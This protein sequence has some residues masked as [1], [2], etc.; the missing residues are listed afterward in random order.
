MGDLKSG[1]VITGSYKLLDLQNSMSV[2][3]TSN[4]GAPT[5][6][7]LH[8]D[9][10]EAT[11]TPSHFP[12]LPYFIGSV[13]QFT[14]GF[15]GNN[16]NYAFANG[17]KYALKLRITVGTTISQKTI[18]FTYFATPTTISSFSVT[19][20]GN[21]SSND[22]LDAVVALQS[23]HGT[24]SKVQFLFDELDTV[25]PGASDKNEESLSVWQPES[26]Y[27]SDNTYKTGVNSL[28]NDRAYR[29]TA[30]A[31]WD[32]GYST[33]LNATDDLLMIAKPVI[34]AN[35]KQPNIQLDLGGGEDTALTVTLGSVLS[36]LYYKPTKVQ[37]LIYNGITLVAS[38][39]VE[40]VTYNAD[41]IFT[42][43]IGQIVILQDQELENST[44][45][46]LNAKFT[47]ILNTNETRTSAGVPITFTK[48]AI[49]L[50]APIID[51][52]W[53]LASGGDPSAVGEET[54][55]G[56]SPVIGI[57]GYFSKTVQFDT[58][59]NVNLES[60]NTEFLIEYSKNAGT[61]WSLVKKCALVQG[62]NPVAGAAEA[63]VNKAG[64]IKARDAAIVESLDGQYVNVVGSNKMFFYI[65]QVQVGTALAFAQ[66]ED[67]LVRVSIIADTSK[68]GDKV[69]GTQ[70][71]SLEMVN[72]IRVYDFV[73]GADSEPFNST[74]DR[75]RLTVNGVQ[76]SVAAT[77]V[78][79]DS[80]PPAYTIADSGFVVDTT[81]NIAVNGK[82]PKVNFY[83]YVN[84]TPLVS[85]N[86]FKVSELTGLCAYAIIDMKT[87]STRFPFFMT[88][89]AYSGLPADNN[90]T[91]YKSKLMHGSVNGLYDSVGLNLIYTGE[92]DFSFRPDITKRHKFVLKTDPNTS[93]T[94][95][96]FAGV[97]DE[98]TFMISLQTSSLGI[99][100]D[101]LLAGNYQF[102]LLEA[103]VDVARVGTG[104]ELSPYGID[105]SFSNLLLNVPVVT[106]D[107]NAFASR[108]KIGLA[109]AV[110]Q[111]KSVVPPPSFS[112]IPV[113]SV[114]LGY[115]VAYAITDPNKSNAVVWGPAVS[116]SVPNKYFPV[117]EDYTVSNFSFKTFNSAT[118]ESSIKFDLTL[119]PVAGA[120][121]RI[122]GVNVYITPKG[123]SQRSKIGSIVTSGNNKTLSILSEIGGDIAR[124]AGKKW[125]DWDSA[126]ISFVAFRDK[127]VNSISRQDESSWSETTKIIDNVP[128]IAAVDGIELEGGIVGKVTKLRWTAGLSQYKV[129]VGGVDDRASEMILPIAAA[130]SPNT[131]AVVRYFVGASG[132]FESVSKSVTFTSASVAEDTGV[133]VDTPNSTKISLSAKRSVPASVGSPNVAYALMGNGVNLGAIGT[134]DSAF[135]IDALLT[136]L[137]V[138]VTA[139]VQYQVA[140]AAANSIGVA[141]DPLLGAYYVPRASTDGDIKLSGGVIGSATS[142]AW[143]L[144]SR[145]VTY[146]IAVGTSSADNVST[147]PFDLKDK[148]TV[149]PA[150]YSIT[151]T[152]KFTDTASFVWLSDF[153][154]VTFTS[155]TASGVGA[156][157]VVRPSD[158]TKL[159]KSGSAALQI[160]SSPVNPVVGGYYDISAYALG[161][162]LSLQEQAN[163]SVKYNVNS[164]TEDRDSVPVSILG[165]VTEYRV[166]SV[167]HVT[168]NGNDKTVNSFELNLDAN[169]LEVEGFISLVLVLTQDGTPAKPEGNE[170]LLQFPF[171][172]TLL[173]TDMDQTIGPNG[174]LIGG[175]AAIPKVSPIQAGI[176]FP[177]S[178][179]LYSLVIGSPATGSPVG[180]YAKSTLTLP[181]GSGF[182]AGAEINVMAILSSRR[183]TDIDV[184]SVT[185]PAV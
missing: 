161:A 5:A 179:L 77:G 140:G 123:T 136:K 110:V 134:I 76:S 75:L 53:S 81:G 9:L 19:N 147:V 59:R 64:A 144:D 60:V 65:P 166:S 35:L 84:P 17:S 163:A 109:D 126:T 8:I 127:R 118:S 61:S 89:T 137:H 47:T 23:I 46:T 88:Y 73:N 150:N 133:T 68:W 180:R 93:A 26:P 113:A 63:V 121:D 106:T 125:A 170:V 114:D 159:Y 162:L 104:S 185:L 58:T 97:Q 158:A 107:E 177:T 80:S 99:P 54:N 66:S 79:A 173:P 2:S 29:V 176:G 67:V 146:D 36:T 108:V 43:K 182:V 14:V 171:S 157:E 132:R 103:G 52:T 22:A 92:D 169:G 31:K 30:L 122:D 138:A 139:G 25:G 32:T 175:G 135:T 20:S 21:E 117:K 101:P 98:R 18:S 143:I 149:S 129:S 86:S 4:D 83:Y 44:P 100:T 130:N 183:G 42:Y 34:T 87:G 102:T 165:N 38:T 45:Y 115:T 72:K 41:K 120:V 6:A 184:G 10:F 111:F 172:S 154:T 40:D 78:A 56:L 37:F 11:G 70:S 3:V 152:K 62:S 28:A 128:L 167:P 96:T 112:V 50:T 141:M 94:K 164:S 51:N 119:N 55:F 13:C 71:N 151:I 33:F 39:A 69:D 160:N 105:M 85:A 178:S 7:D 57:S 82:M 12:L 142:L 74:G 24:P 49:P 153:D 116:K 48:D 95:G 181:A 15:S 174:P 124:N 155:S 131:I 16:I 91:W 27:E 168:V 1:N 90:A 145:G 148:L 156:V